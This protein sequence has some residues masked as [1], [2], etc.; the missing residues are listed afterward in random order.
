VALA[1]AA[2]HDLQVDLRYLVPLVGVKS[3]SDLVR[4]QSAQMRMPGGAYG[5]DARAGRGGRAALARAA[6]HGLHR[7][8][9]HGVP[10]I[11]V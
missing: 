4:P 5:F 9:V 3:S 7:V 6:R 8:C 11:G 10:L 1:L 2:R